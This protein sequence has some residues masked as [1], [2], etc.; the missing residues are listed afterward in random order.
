MTDSLLMPLVESR[1]L[2]EKIDSLDYKYEYQIEKMLRVATMGRTSAASTSLQ[3]YKPRPDLMI[4][5]LAPEESLFCLYLL[6]S[7]F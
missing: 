4:S 2:L 5:K 3:R 1:I 6:C 7:L